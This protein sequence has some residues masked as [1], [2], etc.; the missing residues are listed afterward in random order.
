MAKNTV[1]ETAIVGGGPAGLTAGL[2]LARAG[3]RVILAERGAL[4]GQARWL[5]RIENYPGF[6]RGVDG[7]VLMSR[8]VRQA[9]DWGLRTVHARVRGVRRVQGGYSLRLSPGGALRSRAVVYCP[10]AGC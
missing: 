3:Y 8:W 2:Q 7:G 1:W 6:P 10:G 9:R 4:G 5:G